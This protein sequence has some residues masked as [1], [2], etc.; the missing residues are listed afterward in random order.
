MAIYQKR[1][2]KIVKISGNKA[3]LGNI[4]PVNP[5]VEAF[6]SLPDI[7]TVTADA[8]RYCTFITDSKNQAND[9]IRIKEFILTTVSPYTRRVFVASEDGS[10]EIKFP[11]PDNQPSITIKLQAVDELGNT[12]NINVKTISLIYDNYIKAPVIIAPKSRNSIGSN[13]VVTVNNYDNPK[14][15]V[16]S[17]DY[18]I[19]ADV[20]GANVLAA[21]ENVTS[22]NIFSVT[23][24][25]LGN[26]LTTGKNY[27]V[28]AR[29]KGEIFD[30]SDWSV[31]VTVT[32]T[33]DMVTPSGRSLARHPN[34]KGCIL[35]WDD[36]FINSVFI[37]DYSYWRKLAFGGYNVDI[38]STVEY[39]YG[40]RTVST[41][42]KNVVNSVYLT[43][44]T[45]VSTITDTNYNTLWPYQIFPEKTSAEIND[46]IKKLISPEYKD[47]Q[48]IVGLPAIQYCESITLDEVGAE[49]TVN[50]YC[51]LPKLSTLDRIMVELESIQ[52]IDPGAT[53]PAVTTVTALSCNPS[54]NTTVFSVTRTQNNTTARNAVTSFTIPVFE[55]ERKPHPVT[56]AP[57]GRR[58][59]RHVSNRGTVMEYDDGTGVT[60]R[61]VIMDA[62]YRT[63]GNLIA[64][65]GSVDA[66]QDVEL[67]RYAKTNSK[68]NWFLDGVSTETDPAE[69][70]LMTDEQLN[71]LWADSIDENTGQ[72][73][74]EALAPYSYVIINNCRNQKIQTRLFENE[75][76]IGCSLPNFQTLIRIFCDAETIDALDPTV[77]TDSSI[78]GN[79]CGNALG[80]RNPSGR[81]KGSTYA[82]STLGPDGTTL[83]TVRYDGSCEPT[84][85]LTGFRA[86]PVLEIYP[87]RVETPKILNSQ[88]VIG[89]DGTFLNRT[90]FTVIDGAYDEFEAVEYRLSLDAD[91]KQLIV[92]ESLEP[93]TQYLP[94][95]GDSLTV[96]HYYFLSIRYKSK[97][98]GYTAW[99]E[100]VRVVAKKGLVTKGGRVL[101]RHDSDTGTVLEY[102]DYKWHK[103]FVADSQY[104]I[105]K[106]MYTGTAKVLDLTKIYNPYGLVAAT[107]NV[108]NVL[109]NAYIS[110]EA[111]YNNLEKLDLTTL[112]PCRIFPMQSSKEICNL[113][114]S[115][116][117]VSLLP[118]IEYCQTVMVDDKPCNLPSAWELIQITQEYQE[119]Q[120]LDPSAG[121]ISFWTSDNF[122]SC[123]PSTLTTSSY[124][125][126]WI[127]NPTTISQV[128]SNS[129]TNYRVLPVMELEYGEDA[130]SLDIVIAPSGRKFYR[131]Y[132]NK[133]TVM[134][135][136]DNGVVKRA[137]ILDAR[138]RS[139]GNLLT[140]ATTD[141]LDDVPLDFVTNPNSQNNFYING[142]AISSTAEAP[143]ITDRNINDLWRDLLD[144]S[145]SENNMSALSNTLADN[146]VLKIFSDTSRRIEFYVNGTSHSVTTQVPNINLLIRIFC[147]AEIIDALD[148]TVGKD[149]NALGQVCNLALGSR[150]TFGRWKVGN[151]QYALSSTISGNGEIR[152]VTP[153]GD[154]SPIK[155]SLS[156]SLIPV[157]E[158]WPKA[159]QK[160]VIRN[161][162][163]I[164]G[165]E[166]TWLNISP[167][168]VTKGSYDILQSVGYKVTSD[169]D[170]NNVV[171]SGEIPCSGDDAN[172]L[173]ALPESIS[174]DRHYYL[175]V[176]YKSEEFGYT[177]WSDGL[178][179][180]VKHGFVT[181]GG[182]VLYRHASGMG[183]VMEY[184][185]YKWH[186]L[187]VTDQRYWISKSVT[188][189]NIKSFAFAS[190]YLPYGLAING[191]NNITA[192]ANVNGTT[193][194]SVMSRQDFYTLWP[195]YLFP[196]QSS[197][198]ISGI[199]NKSY[200]GLTKLPALEYCNTITVDDETCH[201]PSIDQ[202][203]HITQE[204]AEL[205][206]RDVSNSVSPSLQN[207]VSCTPVPASYDYYLACNGTTVTS[208]AG[209]TANRVIPVLEL[210]EDAA[211]EQQE[212]ILAPSGRRLYRHF[213][214]KGT[215]M[216]YNDNGVTR[217]AIILDA[218]YRTCGALLTTDTFDRLD[219]L[220]MTVVND[221]N[222]KDNMYLNG[223]TAS[224]VQECRN[225]SDAELDRI[226][227]NATDLNTSAENTKLLYSLDT[228]FVKTLKAIT[229]DFWEADKN[230]SNLLSVQIPNINLLSRIFC[231]AE[232]LDLMDPTVGVDSTVL[233]N[234]CGNALGSRNNNGA[235][236]INNRGY[237]TSSTYAG[238]GELRAITPTGDT[239][240]LKSYYNSGVIPVLEIW[241]KVIATPE[242]TT[243]HN[244]IGT[245]GTYIDLS[246]F[247]LSQ[248]A[249]DLLLTVDYKVTSDELGVNVVIE[250][251]IDAEVVKD[252]ASGSLVIGNHYLNAI[253][254]L[255]TGKTY[256]LSV[257]YSTRTVH[258]DWSK[259]I[260]VV[261][262]HGYVTQFGRT[263]YRHSS[264][265]GTILEY[266]DG[267][268]RKLLVLD[269][270]Y[271]GY[272][273]F[274]AG[275]VTTNLPQ[276]FGYSTGNIALADC[277]DETLNTSTNGTIITTLR[278]RLPSRVESNIWA[279]AAPSID[280]LPSLDSCK[281]ILVDGV[282]CYLPNNDALLR[283]LAES[284]IINK[285]D[286]SDGSV[287]IKSGLSYWGSSKGT[288]TSTNNFIASISGTNVSMSVMTGSA[289]AY[290]IP[291]L[292]LDEPGTSK[293]HPIVSKAGRKI[294]ANPDNKSVTLEYEDK[295]ILIPGINYR[296]YNAKFGTYGT[297]VEGIENKEVN[298]SVGNAFIN[299]IANY[300]VAT[301]LTNPTTD[302]KIESIW[303][304]YGG[305][306]SQSS[307]EICDL[308]MERNEIK[309]TQ[310]TVGVPAV[311]YARS[312]VL[313]GYGRCD[314]PTM[315]IAMRIFLESQ[316]IDVCDPDYYVT[317]GQSFCYNNVGRVILS[318]NENG[319]N[320]VLTL[321]AATG[322]STSTTKG[323]AL[324][325]TPILDTADYTTV[326]VSEETTVDTGRRLYRHSSGIGTVLEYRDGE[327]L[328]KVLILDA[329]YRFLSQFSTSVPSDGS[330]LLVPDLSVYPG[331][332][333]VFV[334]GSSTNPLS[335]KGVLG[336]LT[337][338]EDRITELLTT[339]D[340]NSSSANCDIWSQYEDTAAVHE[341]LKIELPD[342][343]P[344]AVVPNINTL[345]R[346]HVES[347]A[348][349]KLDPTVS[350]YPEKSFLVLYGKTTNYCSSTAFDAT[351]M[352]TLKG[353]AGQILSAAKNGSYTIVPVI[354]L[355]G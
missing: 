295:K 336:S 30:Y 96:G 152:V 155:S 133:G 259:P 243:S 159:V 222:T 253:P 112:W 248:G 327:K 315:D 53:K 19:C 17:A 195:N 337:E 41:V 351:N 355:V 22:P 210:T 127:V 205:V 274:Y 332:D 335:F 71:T 162:P 109:N 153:T 185:D 237:V 287:T 244:F 90:P 266:N 354:D 34:G 138:Y 231:D 313:P 98:F 193:T 59:Y 129:T 157:L 312:C 292:E 321:A 208:V 65:G 218:R 168:T 54:A 26:V 204:M 8:G 33:N 235:W 346:I 3:D 79:I 322:A 137:V 278:N 13:L 60:K 125:N 72:Q 190:L 314:L 341:C 16:I 275:A 21:V 282:P 140:R 69:Y 285:L 246:P 97:E 124:S 207:F 9:K 297:D 311:A 344:Q 14:D 42:D 116:I 139:T 316:Y 141:T 115:T 228:T 345:A 83:R 12:S 48:N 202:V 326:D 296:V 221:K 147:D 225:I 330:N 136:N 255:V 64:S 329:V 158:V 234:V 156:A 256:Y 38:S 67:T 63:S 117:A 324:Y 339:P 347:F 20:L 213:S 10:A 353:N 236:M 319:I 219:A 110:G 175:F 286:E 301:L 11:V 39:P 135:Y 166:G 114:T 233:G 293:D 87:K 262:K 132:S 94:A 325:S 131:H 177:D 323:T 181:K 352:L 107:V 106:R 99:S 229:V 36:G 201:L 104:S 171:S 35:T 18:K 254:A 187:L 273:S 92:Q 310:S 349:D 174:T 214:N 167:F 263:A 77:G 31:P 45:A 126:V 291:V 165:T 294:Y 49:D 80:S 267:Q 142:E 100:P 56:V 61:V 194:Y 119:L 149:D 260:A 249:W 290:Y 281:S 269:A 303:L 111:T 172:S 178:Q 280:A 1:N 216:E 128:A 333:K 134:E 261:A 284:D 334:Y 209:S 288:S 43:N 7:P 299:G 252:A 29:F 70:A 199:W 86:I 93:T 196:R 81:W 189:G 340:V 130:P 151:L 250:D 145:S 146:S 224:N 289:K 192:N 160:P 211:E 89:T 197:K 238:T 183:T 180:D 143:V 82:S 121:S 144:I 342:G 200:N 122:V 240:S 239:T 179:V 173:P 186:K 73:N 163:A 103:L 164:I 232:I 15:R 302:S 170:G 4:L 268:D 338:T 102:C 154:T 50:S 265:A 308:W 2:G 84:S 25:D 270:S 247:T 212:V 161:T 307:R 57:S 320:H 328:A 148:P 6:L 184:Y 76:L 304:Q 62:R 182:R 68:G 305:E 44:V 28:F 226:W 23:F 220:D 245:Q 88:L 350:R 46:D 113:W 101:Y 66:L 272:N 176:R 306:N 191:T 215:V 317:P 257:R 75:D 318:C 78:A 264:G 47:S 85:I 276:L 169:L 348:L 217:R 230:V 5:D 24:E 118:A 32:F 58:Y 251:S 223:V 37:A 258:S 91:G 27:Y 227:E 120:K 283:I 206:K 271:R 55:Y 150:N 277:T 188:S 343:L 309:D 298:N 198:E 123:T 203:M 52:S 95:T 331:L 51:C 241:P 74:S 108:V 105:L 242:I 279:C 300:T 40:L